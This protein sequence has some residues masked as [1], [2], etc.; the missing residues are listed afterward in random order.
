MLPLPC[1]HPPQKK[2]NNNNTR[3]TDT[4]FQQ[5][6]GWVRASGPKLERMLNGPQFKAQPPSTHVH[7]FLIISNQ[8]KWKRRNEENGA[9]KE[10][11]GCRNCFSVNG[12]NG[13]KLV[14]R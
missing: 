10:E 13:E 9:G 2:N 6:R 8:G 11:T 7:P 5:V 1:P 3:K 14:P 12:G 4:T